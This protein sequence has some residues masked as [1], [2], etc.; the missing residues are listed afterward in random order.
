MCPEITFMYITS[1]LSIYFVCRN[2]NSDTHHWSMHT[3]EYFT[4]YFIHFPTC[5]TLKKRRVLID[6]NLILHEYTNIIGVYNNQT[7]P[8]IY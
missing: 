5:I 1:D 8:P 6:T 2:V 7:N 3:G 4:V